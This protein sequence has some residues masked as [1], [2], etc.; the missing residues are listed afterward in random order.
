VLLGDGHAHVYTA[1]FLS[2]L[3]D[4]KEVELGNLDIVVVDPPQGQSVSDPA[5][6]KDFE[7][8]RGRKTQQVHILFLE[9]CLE[10]LKP[11]G[12]LAIIIPESILTQPALGYVRDFL[13]RRAFVRAIIS[14]PAHT[15]VPYWGY[16]ANIILL[17]NKSK[18]LDA[19]DYDVFMV[20]ASDSRKETL[21]EI[22][23]KYMRFKVEV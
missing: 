14:L 2:S 4:K 22:V 20:E 1:D 23:E 3:S 8:G 5:I 13:L 21:D 12:R 19:G 16:K 10:V 17:Q 11:T 6:L 18:P 15:F 9:K 7:L